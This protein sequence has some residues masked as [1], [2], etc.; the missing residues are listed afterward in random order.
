MNI[1]DLLVDEL[2]SRFK[3]L[4]TDNT[5]S[6]EDDSKAVDKT[7]KL[8]DK[9]IEL[10]RVH[11]E[12][13]DKEAIRE[14]DALMKQKQ[15]DEDKKDHLIKNILSAAGIALPLLVTIWGT[16]VSLKFEEEGTFTTMA[17]RNFVGNL[18]RRK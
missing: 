2:E 9:Y 6:E 15:L 4:R 17:G 5:L 3:K 12:R 8:L 14:N 16:K 10:E 18:F 7:A 1:E 11:N 13:A